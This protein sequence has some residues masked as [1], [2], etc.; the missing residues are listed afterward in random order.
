MVKSLPTNFDK[1][2]LGHELTIFK[3]KQNLIGII[4]ICSKCNNKIFFTKYP[5]RPWIYQ[6][7][8]FAYGWKESFDSCDELIIKKLLE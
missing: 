6:I 5:E 4:Y 2:H 3:G 7:W 1:N 8:T